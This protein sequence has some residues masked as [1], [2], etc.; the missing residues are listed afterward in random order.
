MQVRHL[1]RG[2]GQLLR[3]S[4]TGGSEPPAKI[5]IVYQLSERRRD[6]LDLTR[7]DQ[8]SA[9]GIHDF[10]AAAEPRSYN[11]KAG[12]KRFDEC[13]PESLRRDIRLTEDVRSREDLRN[14]RALADEAHPIRD[15]PGAGCGLELGFIG[16][17][18]ATLC[19]S[20]EPREP[21]G[22]FAR[23]F[24]QLR[25]RRKMNQ[26][27]FQPFRAAYL[28]DHCGVSRSVKFAPY[29]EAIPKRVI[30]L[31]VCDRRVNHRGRYSGKN[32]W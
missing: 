2:I 24:A 16:N 22:L 9:T 29:P 18:V 30:V 6:R 14:V 20:D 31:R 4:R 10:E 17:F 5:A 15:S 19:S 11:R 25:E 8:N 26:M 7:R 13:D 3:A 1:N 12:V 28:Y 32:H 27:T 23:Y 21:F